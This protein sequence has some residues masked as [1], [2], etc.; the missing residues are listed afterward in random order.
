MGSGVR[1]G[2]S[3]KGAHRLHTDKP[4]GLTLGEWGESLLSDQVK[5]VSSQGYAWRFGM[6]LIGTL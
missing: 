6:G 2:L 4:L 3:N 5:A 1:I